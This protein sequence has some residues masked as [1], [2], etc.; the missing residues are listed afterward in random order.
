MTDKFIH[1]KIE[2]F[3]KSEGFIRYEMGELTYEDSAAYVKEDTVVFVNTFY[4]APSDVIQ[5]IKKEHER[6][7]RLKSMR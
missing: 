4:G 6:L 3:M 5:D 2:N 1:D 7:R